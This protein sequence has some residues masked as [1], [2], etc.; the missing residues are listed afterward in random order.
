VRSKTV[1]L[2]KWTRCWLAASVVFG[3]A[4]LFAAFTVPAYNGTISQTL[5]EASGKKVI[6]IVAVPLVGALL[7]MG[8][9]AARRR[10]ER[11]G[12]GITTWLLLGALGALAALGVL[13]IGPFVAQC[14]SAYWWP[15]YESRRRDACVRRGNRT[16]NLSRRHPSSCH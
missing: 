14:R 16:L 6:F 4:L 2:D 3:A 15:Y 5:V 11:E 1:R 10:R 9:I 8:T 13:T 7:A 12:V